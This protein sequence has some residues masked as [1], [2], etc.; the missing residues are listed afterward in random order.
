M[1]MG[2]PKVY[3]GVQLPEPLRIN[4][5]SQTPAPPPSS[6]GLTFLGEVGAEQVVLGILGQGLDVDGSRVGDGATKPLHL[7]VPLRRVQ[8]EVEICGDTQCHHPRCVGQALSQ[9]VPVRVVPGVLA[10]CWKLPSLR[11]SLL[12]ALLLSYLM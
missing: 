11:S 8:G 2:I 1:V 3:L 5:S 9:Q 4:L 7:L 12:P 6:V 10:L